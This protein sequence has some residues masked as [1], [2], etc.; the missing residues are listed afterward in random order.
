M[1]LF[2]QK[3]NEV[4]NELFNADSRSQIHCEELI[5]FTNIGRN[6]YSKSV[7]HLQLLMTF[8]KSVIFLNY[9]HTI[10]HRW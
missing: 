4:S 5:H 3:K 2:P 6:I 1:E 7:P 8:L 9:V 10:Y